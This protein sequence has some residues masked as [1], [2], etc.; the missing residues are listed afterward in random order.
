MAT[1]AIAGEPG[2]LSAIQ[3]VVEPEPEHPEPDVVLGQVHQL[4]AG[5]DPGQHEVSVGTP[6]PTEVYAALWLGAL[7]VAAGEFPTRSRRRSRSWR[8]P[9][10]S[11]SRRT[12]RR[13]R[14]ASHLRDDVVLA[15]VADRRGR[16]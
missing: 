8:G 16:G 3:D 6:G 14:P 13:R 4:A 9:T 11:G 10:S 7:L 2:D 12:S 5:A 15:R 1:A